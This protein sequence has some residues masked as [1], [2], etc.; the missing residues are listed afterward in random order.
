M[1]VVLGEEDAAAAFCKEWVAEAE[2]ADGGV[3]LEP[4]AVGDRN[5]R[6]ISLRPGPPRNRRSRS[7]ACSS[8]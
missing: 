8:W 1:E 5:E 4:A 2:F 7:E 3:K 6:D